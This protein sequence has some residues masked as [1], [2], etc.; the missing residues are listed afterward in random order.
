MRKFRPLIIACTDRDEVARL[1]GE[2]QYIGIFAIPD[3]RGCTVKVT[4]VEYKPRPHTE[5]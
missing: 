2:Y 5:N 3:W 1:V 4:S